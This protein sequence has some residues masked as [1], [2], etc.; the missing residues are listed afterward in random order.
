MHRKRERLAV[1][2]I[3]GPSLRQA[4]GAGSVAEQVVNQIDVDAH[5]RLPFGDLVLQ[6]Q[7]QG[8]RVLED[9]ATMPVNPGDHLA[10]A[11]RYARFLEER[12]RQGRSS[13]FIKMHSVGREA[14][15]RLSHVHD[16]MS[17]RGNVGEVPTCGLRGT[18]HF[19]G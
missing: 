17:R 12:G 14:R 5:T 19:G 9:D 4:L 15:R 1:A 10:C 3:F 16:D 7:E 2:M 8:H 11:G 6:G 13:P 18:N